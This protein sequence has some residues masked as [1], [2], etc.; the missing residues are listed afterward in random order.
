[1]DMSQ[2]ALLVKENIDVKSLLNFLDFLKPEILQL[3]EKQQKWINDGQSQ[4]D[5]RKHWRPEKVWQI[6]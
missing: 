3:E 4:T 5:S 6:R 2:A 1:M